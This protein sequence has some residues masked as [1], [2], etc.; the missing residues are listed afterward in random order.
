MSSPPSPPSK[1]VVVADAVVVV[2]VN[3]EPKATNVTQESATAAATTLTPP[4]PPQAPQSPT[5]KSKGPFSKLLAIFKPSSSSS[6][7]TSASTPL[8]TLP[9]KS[10]DRAAK[11]SAKAAN[12]VV[13]AVSAAIVEKKPPQTFV[14]SIDQGTSSSRFIVFD[15][16]GAIVVEHQMEFE[17]IYPQAGEIGEWSEVLA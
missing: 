5:P 15:T 11:M 10:V 7:S 1:E 13:Q 16:E 3:E 2:A 17:Q 8:F 6:D 4:P 14:G 9:R 12:T